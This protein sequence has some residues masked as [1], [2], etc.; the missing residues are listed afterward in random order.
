[1]RWNVKPE[2]AREVGQIWTKWFFA[3]RK[4]RVKTHFVW[5]EFYEVTYRLDRVEGNVQYWVE[6][7]RNLFDCY[8]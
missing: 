3:W 5:L 2:P 7:D 6:T 4:T 1:M 8:C